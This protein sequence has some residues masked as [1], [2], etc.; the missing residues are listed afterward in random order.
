MLELRV[1]LLRRAARR[2]FDPWPPQARS[3]ERNREDH[4]AAGS[5]L[6]LALTIIVRSPSDHRTLSPRRVVLAAPIGNVQRNQILASLDPRRP[7]VDAGQF[8]IRLR[9]G[10][11]GFRAAE[12]DRT[13]GKAHLTA[14]LREGISRVGEASISP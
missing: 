14:G 4:W 7:A 2:G 11:F 10:S 3:A 6:L 12:P 9:R 8:V 1:I 13:E 5:Q